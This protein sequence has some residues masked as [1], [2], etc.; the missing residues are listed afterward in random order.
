MENIVMIQEYS[1]RVRSTSMKFAPSF[2]ILYFFLVL[3]I[4]P[5][6]M[7]SIHFLSCNFNF[8]I[9]FIDCAHV[10]FY[11]LTHIKW[12]HTSAYL[13]AYAYMTVLRLGEFRMPIC[14]HM[15]V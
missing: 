2:I 7:F 6:K 14:V 3:D 11:T 13:C 4:A 1:Y 12:A 5:R 10:T 15:T 8:T 9:I